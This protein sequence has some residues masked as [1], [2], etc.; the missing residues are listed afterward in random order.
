MAGEDKL[1]QRPLLASH[2]GCRRRSQQRSEEVSRN[3]AGTYSGLS[4][5]RGD[6]S[7]N[8]PALDTL[9]LSQE[10]KRALDLDGRDTDKECIAIANDCTD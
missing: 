10:G 3:L 9:G 1:W 4:H 7:W 2:I 5:S 8:R 6:N